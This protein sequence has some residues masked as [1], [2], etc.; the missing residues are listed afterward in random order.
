MK[1]GFYKE[2]GEECQF[3]TEERGE[4]IVHL[5]ENHGHQELNEFL[6]LNLE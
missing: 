2:N 4:M 3:E 6:M 1:C 5:I